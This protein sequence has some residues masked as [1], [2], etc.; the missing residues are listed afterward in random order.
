MTAARAALRSLRSLRAARG[1]RDGHLEV[2][3]TPRGPSPKV[4]SFQLPL[5]DSMTRKRRRFTAE[6]KKR[7]A[8]EALREHLVRMHLAV[9]AVLEHRSSVLPLRAPRTPAGVTC[10]SPRS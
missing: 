2:V 10:A 1:H 7:V 4:C 8:L 3:N 5:T 9:P 6:F